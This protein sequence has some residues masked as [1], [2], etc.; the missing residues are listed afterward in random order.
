MV[1][2]V[3]LFLLGP[4]YLSPH[5]S[6]TDIGLTVT[7]VSPYF[8]MRVDRIVS[9][10]NLWRCGLRQN[11]CIV[12]VNGNN[13]MNLD[14]QVAITLFLQ[15]RQNEPLTM[16][17]LRG[18]PGENT[19]ILHYTTINQISNRH[20]T[21]ALQFESYTPAA[22]IPEGAAVE[23]DVLMYIFA[24][25]MFNARAIPDRI[26]TFFT[27][28]VCRRSHSASSAPGCASEPPT[29]T[30]A[31]ISIYIHLYSSHAEKVC[32][33]TGAFCV[34]KDGFANRQCRQRKC[35]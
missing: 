32:R 13:T 23:F 8:G 19:Y 33:C 22:D 7:H 30:C 27:V 31:S 6:S 11:D 1:A 24:I 12:S 35:R 20:R 26:V 4:V 5:E 34:C 10:C 15:S 14:P 18:L 17:V 28:R 2:G 21:H 9:S 29:G 16:H 25:S 3:A